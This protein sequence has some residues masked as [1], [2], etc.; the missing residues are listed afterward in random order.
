MH[1]YTLLCSGGSSALRQLAIFETKTH[2]DACNARQL[3]NRS[4]S[5][6][7]Q[8]SLGIVWN[9]HGRIKFYAHKTNSGPTYYGLYRIEVGVLKI[10]I[11]ALAHHRVRISA[12][13]DKIHCTLYVQPLKGSP[14]RD[15]QVPMCH[16]AQWAHCVGGTSQYRGEWARTGFPPTTP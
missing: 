12:H 2:W 6:T 13:P 11:L 16:R 14:W 8:S 5:A 4:S 9:V 7:E 10:R 3:S 1:I 15:W